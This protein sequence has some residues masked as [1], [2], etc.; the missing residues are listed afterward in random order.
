MYLIKKHGE[1]DFDLWFNEENFFGDLKASDE[2]KKEAPAND[3]ENFLECIN[4]HD[5]FW[6]I[7]YEHETIKDSETDGYPATKFRTHFIRDNHE[8]NPKKPWNEL[9]NC[10]RMKLAVKFT[11]MYVIELNKVNYKSVL[12]DFKQ[13]RQPNGDARKIKFKINKS[14]I[15]NLVVYRHTFTSDS[16]FVSPFK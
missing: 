3:Q 9:S 12:N 13:G 7:I 1:L 5:K 16:E 11:N 10:S 8:W 4:T 6:Y 2:A 15:D 14:N